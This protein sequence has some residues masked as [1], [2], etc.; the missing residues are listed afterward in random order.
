MVISGFPIVAVKSP[1]IV[2]N[3][4]VE[5]DMGD[6]VHMGIGDQLTVEQ[7]VVGDFGHEKIVVHVILERLDQ[8]NGTLI[9]IACGQIA[10]LNSDGFRLPM[11]FFRVRCGGGYL[12]G[13]AVVVGLDYDGF[14]APSQDHDESET[15]QG[16]TPISADGAL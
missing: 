8:R 10:R 7:G 4:G 2:Y 1:G 9:I 5:E 11:Q 15:N 6:L 13:I 16:K 3:Q 14:Y 12:Y